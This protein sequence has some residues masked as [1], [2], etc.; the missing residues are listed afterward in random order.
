[1]VTCTKTSFLE[2]LRQADVKLGL[3]GHVHEERA[4]LVGYVHPRKIHIVGA[5]SFG[6]VK[7]DRPESTPRLYNMMEIARNQN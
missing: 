1:M 6:A 2:K 4:D 3:H 5:G 7:E